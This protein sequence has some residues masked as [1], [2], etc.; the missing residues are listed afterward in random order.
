MEV[1]CESDHDLN[2]S[3][4]PRAGGSFG[5]DRKWGGGA[6]QRVPR[7]FQYTHRVNCG[8]IDGAENA[9]ISQYLGVRK[10]RSTSKSQHRYVLRS[11][12]K[13]VRKNCAK[14]LHNQ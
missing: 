11:G 12:L 14:R 4:F 2:G 7:I 6:V 10:S 1:V 3:F 13:A 9:G 5:C 8:C